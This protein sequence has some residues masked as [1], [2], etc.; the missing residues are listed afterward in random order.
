VAVVLL[1]F[2]A[3]A[4]SRLF[5]PYGFIISPGTFALLAAILFADSVTQAMRLAA[6]PVRRAVRPVFRYVPH[7][8]VIVLVL[9]S[10]GQLYRPKVGF[11][12]L[13]LF[14]KAFEPARLPALRDVPHW[15]E[16]GAGYD[17]QFYAQL[18]VDPFLRSG[19]IATALDSPPYRAR[20]ILLPWTAHL[21]GWGDPWRTLQA[22]A[23][24]NVASWLLLAFL[25][26]Y[27]L[28]PG[29]ARPVLAWTACLLSEGL[30]ASMRRSVPDGPSVLVLALAILAV[31]KN[32]RWLGAALLGLAGLT[33]ETNLLGG[34]ILIPERP[35]VRQL[36][37]FAAQGAFAAAPIAL[38]VLHLW[39]IGYP[40]NDT[41]LGNFG[42]PLASYVTKWSVTVRDLLQGGWDSYARFSLLTLVALTT[43]ACFFA[44]Q[45]DWRSGWWRVGAVY[46]LFMI[47]LGD[48]VWEGHPAAVG[49]VLLPMTVAFNVMLPRLRWRVF[50]PFWILGNGSVVVGLDAMKVPWLSTP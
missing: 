11:T 9:W 5:T 28:R 44:W 15:V 37:A 45:R 30:L 22:Y 1:L 38:W 33:R 10:V 47:V 8:T 46:A 25:L 14:G 21:L 3:G 43:Q 2:V 27:W 26:L 36:A 48:A 40:P 13:I 35:G 18:A 19:S 20:R 17:G 34:A 41:G 7:A 12:T 4:V 49:R 24:L 31:E 32:R 39:W 42:V 29:S 23:L 16:F 6:P 50:L